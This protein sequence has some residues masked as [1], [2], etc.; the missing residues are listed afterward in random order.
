MVYEYLFFKSTFSLVDT[1]MLQNPNR[2]IFSIVIKN[3]NQLILQIPEQ[4]EVPLF[5][6]SQNYF[7]IN[8]SVYEFTFNINEAGEVESLTVH[9][10][11]GDSTPAN[12]IED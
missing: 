8:G 9:P 1:D 7:F 12:R 2:F 10:D 5:P 3:D 6:R 11:G 4:G